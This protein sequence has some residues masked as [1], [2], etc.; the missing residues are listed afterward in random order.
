MQ[1]EWWVLPINKRL[2]FLEIVNTFNLI[3]Q[4][5]KII[6]KSIPLYEKNTN[7]CFCDFGHS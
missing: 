2:L 3:N 7:P 4:I 1:N 6:H 5:L